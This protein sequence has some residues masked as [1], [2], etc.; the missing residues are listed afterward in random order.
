MLFAMD[1]G[2]WMHRHVWFGTPMAHLVSTDRELLLAYGAAVG[3]P[4]VHQS[5]PIPARHVQRHSR[6]DKRPRRFGRPRAGSFSTRSN[7]LG[8]RH[9]IDRHRQV[10]VQ[11][12]IPDVEHTPPGQI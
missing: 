12:H 1:G 6:S 5:V 11:R 3:L 2:L 9:R 4:G 8:A 10:G 7:H